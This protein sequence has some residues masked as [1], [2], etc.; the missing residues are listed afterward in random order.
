[1]R[2]LMNLGQ[3]LNVIVLDLVAMA[4]CLDCLQVAIFEL[5]QI[6][7][8]D[9]CRN[10]HQCM[11]MIHVFLIK[12]TLQSN[13]SLGF[14]RRLKKNHFINQLTWFSYHRTTDS[15]LVNK[16]NEIYPRYIVYIVC[17]LSVVFLSGTISYDGCFWYVVAIFT[18]FL[19]PMKLWRH[20]SHK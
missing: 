12:P 20:N 14:S 4:V 11:C 19:Q 16:T 10:V 9:K 5:H 2:R 17:E 15:H 8:E 1:M 13:S 18:T 6:F 7:K 3:C